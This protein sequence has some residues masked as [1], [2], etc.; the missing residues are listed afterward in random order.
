[1]WVRVVEAAPCWQRTCG[2]PSSSRV[3]TDKLQSRQTHSS[4]SAGNAPLLAQLSGKGPA[5][6]GWARLGSPERG[7]AKQAR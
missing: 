6:V 1:M 3:I 4:I 2:L 7:C 5:R